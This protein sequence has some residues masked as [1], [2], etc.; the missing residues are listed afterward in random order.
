MSR[1]GGRRALPRV[2]NYV[3]DLTNGLTDGVRLSAN[4]N[5]TNECALPLDHGHTRLMILK[6]PS[7]KSAFDEQHV[8][9]VTSLTM[10]IFLSGIF[11]G[12]MHGYAE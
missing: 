2:K 8:G 7:W 11:G 4:S 9:G 10:D 1:K 6:R 12:F 3:V 5:L